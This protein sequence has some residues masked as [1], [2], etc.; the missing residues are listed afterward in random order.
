MY[1]RS[2]AWPFDRLAGTYNDAPGPF[3]DC[4]GRLGGCEVGYGDVACRIFVFPKMPI[5]IILR[6]GDEAFPPKGE[7]YFDRSARTALPPDVL[8]GIADLTV[9][10]FLKI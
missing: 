10:L 9:E 1:Y 3:L 6:F 7:L 5:T 4:A 2:T 8:W